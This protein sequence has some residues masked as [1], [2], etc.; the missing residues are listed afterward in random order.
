MNI[1]WFSF[2]ASECAE[3]YSDKHVVK[4]IL[5]IAQ[6][7]YASHVLNDGTPLDGGYRA[8]HLGHPMT[9]WVATCVGNYNMAVDLGLA[10]CHEYTH[11]Y[12]KVHA[13][14]KHL[15]RLQN[16]LPKSWEPAVIKKKATETVFASLD[17]PPQCTPVPLC[18]PEDCHD[19][20]VI[21][22]YKKYYIT[23]KQE[24]N[25]WTKTRCAPDWYLL[26]KCQ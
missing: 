12:G 1:F 17:V 26:E 18:M 11:R 6:M 2:V 19:K 8:T 22:A 13:C 14:A 9:R 15:L 4:I 21:S 5:E 24:I 16:E 3:A 10:L 7:L 25:K 20:S 23:H